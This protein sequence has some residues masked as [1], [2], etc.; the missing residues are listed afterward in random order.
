PALGLNLISWEP[1]NNLMEGL[2]RLDAKHNAAP[3]TAEK[4]DISADGKT[5]TFHLRQNAKWSDGS[6]VTAADFV[7]GW[8]QLLTPATASPAAFLL[9]DIVGAQDF[10]AGKAQTDALDVKS[11]DEHTLDITF[12]A[13]SLSLLNILINP[14]IA[15]DNQKVNQAKP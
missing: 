7:Y 9:Y 2:V 13:T 1:L 15:P 5:Y 6:P 11:L 14:G 8:T 4:W 12:K 10:N 3:A